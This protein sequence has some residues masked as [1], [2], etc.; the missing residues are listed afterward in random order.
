LLGGK[1]SD[2]IRQPRCARAIVDEPRRPNRHAQ[3]NRGRSKR[4]VVPV[5]VPATGPRP[6]GYQSGATR[7]NPFDSNGNGFVRPV[8]RPAR[9]APAA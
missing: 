1:D 9:I 4:R 8:L 5:P 6:A 3:G 2:R 7:A